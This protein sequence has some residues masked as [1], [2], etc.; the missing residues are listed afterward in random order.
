MNVLYKRKR[1]V[2]KKHIFLKLRKIIS[3]KETQNLFLLARKFVIKAASTEPILSHGFP[4]MFSKIR[5]IK[6]TSN[7]VVYIVAIVCIFCRSIT[8]PKVLNKKMF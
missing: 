7:G 4:Y 8:F 3:E 1:G 5:G 6:Q 2:S